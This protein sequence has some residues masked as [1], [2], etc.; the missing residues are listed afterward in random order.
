MVWAVLGRRRGRPGT[1][2]EQLP[3]T[4]QYVRAMRP[5]AQSNRPTPAMLWPSRLIDPLPGNE[6]IV[7]ASF[8]DVANHGAPDLLLAARPGHVASHP[9][10]PPTPDPDPLVLHVQAVSRQCPPLAGASYRRALLQLS[11]PSATLVL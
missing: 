3:R 6:P 1:S 4:G 9:V 5:P 7:Q 8:G 2:A 10:L 11:L